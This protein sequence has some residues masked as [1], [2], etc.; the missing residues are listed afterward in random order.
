MLQL[1]I[2]DEVSMVGNNMLMS[3]HR[4]LKE[5]KGGTGNSPFGSVSILKKDDQPFAASLNRIREANQVIPVT[6]NIQKR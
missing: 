3:I 4:C 1:L 5:I 2:I 6:A